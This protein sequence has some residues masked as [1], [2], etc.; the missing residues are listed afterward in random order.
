MIDGS[1]PS[2]SC[3][4]VVRATGGGKDAE[5]WM[6]QGRGSAL[7][8]AG[9]DVDELAGA[10]QC[11]GQADR[12]FA[13]EAG[14][15]GPIRQEGKTVDP[16]VLEADDRSCLVFPVDAGR[17]RSAQVSAVVPVTVQVL[18][19]GVGH[20]GDLAQLLVPVELV[21]VVRVR[22]LDPGIGTELD[23]T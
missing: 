11:L 6:V 2:R 10:A 3:C 7:E 9:R 17:A 23:R 5:P 20:E 1:E 21:V 14:E 18:G 13:V 16:D 4:S 8:G 22:A 15:Y 19:K 12:G